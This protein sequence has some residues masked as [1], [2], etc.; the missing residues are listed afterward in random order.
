MY[1]LYEEHFLLYCLYI[2][3]LVLQAVIAFL[4]LIVLVVLLFFISSVFCIIC[5]LSSLFGYISDMMKHPWANMYYLNPK[6]EQNKQLYELVNRIS[7][8]IKGPKIHIIYISNEFNAAVTS[9]YTLTPFRRNVLLLGYPLL[10]SLSFR[11]LTG[12]LGHEIGHLSHNHNSSLVFIFM[13]HSFCTNIHLGIF[14]FV[15]YPWLKYWLLAIS[16]TILPLY[17]KYEIEADRY[18]VDTLGKE[19]A[20]AFQVEIF[21]KSHLFRKYGEELFYKMLQDDWSEYDI[22]CQMRHY[23]QNNLPEEQAIKKLQ[24]GIQSIPN[25]LDEHP[26]FSERLKLAGDTNIM[27]YAH[28]NADAFEQFILFKNEFC[29]DINQYFH[30]ILAPNAESIRQNKTEADQ[31]LQKH[32]LSVEMNQD[33]IYYALEALGSSGRPEE[34]N[35]FLDKCLSLFPDNPE[36]L[37]RKALI[38]A[39]DDPEEAKNILEKSLLKAPT[40]YASTASDFLLQYYMDSGEMEKLKTFLKISEEGITNVIKFTSAT[41]SEKDTLDAWPMTQEL[42]DSFCELFFKSYKIINRAYCVQRHIDKQTSLSTVFIV[43]ELKYSFWSYIENPV[44]MCNKLNQNCDSFQFEI[45]PTKFC[46]LYL[47]PIP[48]ACFYDRN[49]IKNSN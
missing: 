23:L 11:G 48:N 44:D 45:C 22:A 36:L 30:V 12:C 25:I 26:S 37:C 43:L 6:L 13:I 41:L 2:G 18:I 3:W 49:N 27:D 38:I 19:Y 9:K 15:L 4:V 21:L 24:R 14:S 20:I 47:D 8:N 28:F 34:R 7:R 5:L 17:R 39:D 46:R 31:W 10:C 35:A 40:L 33:E 42:Q 29:N 32:P 1:C 16:R